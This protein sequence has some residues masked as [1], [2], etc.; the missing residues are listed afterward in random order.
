MHLRSPSF[1]LPALLVAGFANIAQAQATSGALTVVVTDR[2]TGEI[3]KGARVVLSSPA[4]F[5]ERTY[6][7]DAR[8]QIHA[9]LLPVGNYTATVMHS[10]FL[11]AKV[12]DV[13]IGV[14]SNLSQNVDLAPLSSMPGTMTV[15]TIAAS[16]DMDGGTDYA[17]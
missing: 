10:G 15:T 9:V 14:G 12:L 2:T 7:A 17:E 3:L 16:A 13:R 1:L 4:L 5:Q 6:Q 8:G 11:T